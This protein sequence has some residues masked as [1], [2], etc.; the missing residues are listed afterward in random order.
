MLPRVAAL[1]YVLP[2]REGGSLPAVVDGDD[3]ATWVAKFRGAGQGAAVLAAEVI[4]GGIAR[5][6]G[7]AVPDLAIVEVDEA[8]ARNEGDPEIRALLAAS[9]GDNLGMRFLPAALP[10]DPAARPDVDATL[11]SRIV[12]F[13][14]LVQ[15]VDR[16]AKN[17]NLLWSGRAL[18]LIDHGAALYWQHAWDG[19]TSGAAA[20]YARGKEHVLLPWAS[21]LAQAA[22]WLATLTD[23]AIAAIVADVPPAWLAQPAA[24]YVA[25]L[26]ARRDA[27][28]SIL[29]EVASARA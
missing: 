9:A 2:L 29:A 13:D 10:F 1:R 23:E 12:A 21:Q 11:A 22:P 20:R 8:L 26:A 18:W 16:T 19:S 5:A 6:L 7:L 14:A 27:M 17:P 25:R 3:G 4:A 28:P 15:N 24:A